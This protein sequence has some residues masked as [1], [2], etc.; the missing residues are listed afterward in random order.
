MLQQAIINTQIKKKKLSQEIEK[1]IYIYT[2]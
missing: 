1:K 2:N